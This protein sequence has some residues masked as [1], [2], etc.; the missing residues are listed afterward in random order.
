MATRVKSEVLTFLIA[1][2]RGYTTFTRTHGDEAGSALAV[3]FA[4]I[5]REGVETHAGEIL[6]LKGDEAVAV[7]RSA[8]E[9]LR[10]LTQADLAEFAGTT[11]ATANQM[12]REEQERGTLE[13]RRGQTRIVDRDAIAQR[14]RL[15][16]G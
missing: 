8:R 15:R 16:N 7:F 14:A 1:D 6:Q 11:R 3:T 12:L 5:A 10:A 4:E 2:I 9:A 13:L